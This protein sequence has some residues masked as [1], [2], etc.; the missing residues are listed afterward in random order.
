MMTVARSRL[1]VVLAAAILGAASAGRAE[2]AKRRGDPT[3]GRRLFVANGC[4]ACHGRMGQ[5]GAFNGAV[6]MVA[7]TQL[8]LEAVEQVLREPYGD[9]PTYSEVVVSAK[10][11]ADIHAYLQSLPPPPQPKDL[12]DILKR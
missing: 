11:I 9:M 12:P 8:P 5:G 7:A 2:D 3:N 1:L 6:P 10:D 4:F